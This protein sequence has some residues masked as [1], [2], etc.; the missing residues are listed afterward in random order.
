MKGS[1]SMAELRPTRAM[2]W[3]ISKPFS[4]PKLC[5]LR[6]RIGMP[7]LLSLHTPPGFPRD[8]GSY[9][10]V[11][12]KSCPV[13]TIQYIKD[14]EPYKVFI[15]FPLHLLHRGLTLN[16]LC[17]FDTMN[18]MLPC[19]SVHFVHLS[20]LGSLWFLAYCFFRLI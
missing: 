18:D 4:L 3:H 19:Q 9:T 8:V 10:S 17:P 1:Y 7:D 6:P 20:S 5:M 15:Y 16:L 14:L 13:L 2:H 11:R 12:S